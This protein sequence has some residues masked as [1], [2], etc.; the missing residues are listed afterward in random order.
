MSTAVK[1]LEKFPEHCEVLLGP[2]LS[3]RTK[4]PHT[5]YAAKPVSQKATRAYQDI[6]RLSLEVVMDSWGAGETLGSL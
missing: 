2:A 5:M 3:L 6:Y 4:P 1:A